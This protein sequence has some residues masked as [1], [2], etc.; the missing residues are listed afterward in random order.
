M[1]KILP[2]MAACLMISAAA[3]AAPSTSPVFQ[4]RLVLEAPSGDSE[5]MT[6]VSKEAQEVV[7]V[8]KLVLLDQTALKSAGVRTDEFGHARIEVTFTAEGRKRFA[9]I[10]REQ[11]GQ[12]LAI[13]IDDRLY[14]APTIRTEIPGGKAEI[15]GSFSQEGAKALA[16]KIVAAIKK[17]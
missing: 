7:N 9:K 17:Q 14:C 8:Q 11:V 12:R 13:I 2:L 4:I 6:I 15:S 16:A 3:F 10:T 1:K 5:P